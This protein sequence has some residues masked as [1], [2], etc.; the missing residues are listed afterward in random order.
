MQKSNIL[1]KIYRKI[2][3][4]NVSIFENISA[5]QKEAAAIFFGTKRFHFITYVKNT[6]DFSHW[7]N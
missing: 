2:F 1:Y 5:Q 4:K 7:M 6:R 3:L